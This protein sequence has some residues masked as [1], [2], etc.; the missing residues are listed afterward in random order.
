MLPVIS[1]LLEDDNEEV[2]RE[3][4]AWVREIEGVT[5]ESLEGMLS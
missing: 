3:C 1:E 5:G 2:E 4:L